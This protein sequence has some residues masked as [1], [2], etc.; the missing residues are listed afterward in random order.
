MLVSDN[1]LNWKEAANGLIQIGISLYFAFMFVRLWYLY[2]YS[3]ILFSFMYPD[4]VLVL[5]ITMSLSGFGIGCLVISKKLKIKNGY[6]FLIGLWI[7][8]LMIQEIVMS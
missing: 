4:W 3:S 6:F 1:I 8:G 7:L 5:F 2:H